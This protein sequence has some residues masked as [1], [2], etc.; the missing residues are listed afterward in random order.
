[1]VGDLMSKH[2]SALS[3]AINKTIW[4]FNHGQYRYM[5]DFIKLNKSG[6]DML[7]LGLF[8]DAKEI[9][10]S[11]GVLNAVQTKLKQYDLN[12]PEVTLVSV[13][14]GTTPRTAALFAFR[15]KWQCISIDP[16]LKQD[17]MRYWEENIQRLKCIPNKVEDVSIN[18]DKVIIV[19]VHSHAN[20]R[21]ILDHV[22]GKVRSL[23]AIP[24]CVPYI[25]ES[26]KPIAYTDSGIWSPRNNVKIWRTI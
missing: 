14:D 23:V 7:H 16:I 17:K 10:E 22:K 3:E 24:C 21:S 20:L 4:A 15:T 18:E 5:N 1:M 13:G 2:N 26:I 12:D 9:T 8:P 25:H 11:Y 6:S 19:A